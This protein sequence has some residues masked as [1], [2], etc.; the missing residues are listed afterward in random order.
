[1]EHRKA[2]GPMD[3]YDVLGGLQFKVL[4]DLGLREYHTLLDIGCGSLRGGRLFI[5]YLLAG[6]YNGIEPNQYLVRAGI[7]RELGQSVIELKRPQIVYNEEFV[8]PHDGPFDFILAQSIFS[9]ASSDQID[10]CL[11]MVARTM[12]TDGTFVATFFR[13][14]APQ[15]PTWCKAIVR[16]PLADMQRRAKEQGLTLQVLDY[17]HPSGQTWVRMDRQ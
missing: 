11:N 8:P 7:D 14:K 3:K 6:C 16:Y 12:T 9:H 4:F 15:A 17:E 2:V 1:M 5:V 10:T 13:G